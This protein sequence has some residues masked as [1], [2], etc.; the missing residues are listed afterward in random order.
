MIREG[1][2]GRT[3]AAPANSGAAGGPS[4][5]TKVPCGV[6]YSGTQA[7]GVHR[8]VRDFAHASERPRTVKGDFS[9]IAQRF[10]VRLERLLEWAATRYDMIPTSHLPP[11]GAVERDA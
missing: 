6:D 1:G 11:P 2:A 3:T 9:G 10:S 5:R 8:P 7:R 4:A